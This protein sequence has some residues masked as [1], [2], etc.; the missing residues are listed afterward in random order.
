MAE[1]N[2]YIKDKI[3]SISI[4]LF[5]LILIVNG[6]IKLIFE[7]SDR[8]SSLISFFF[9]AI[10]FLHFIIKVLPIIYKRSI[11]VLL[12]SYIL[13]IILYSLSILSISSR[14]ENITYLFSIYIF[15]SFVFWIPVGVTAYSIFN[16]KILYDLLIKYSFVFTAV[17]LIVFFKSFIYMSEE[18]AMYYSMSFSYYTLFPAILHMSYYLKY[19]SKAFLFVSIT[20]VLMILLIGSRGALL[21]ILVYI[22]IKFLISN[23]S[24]FFKASR[25][26]LIVSLLLIFYLKL[27]DI[28]NIFI[29]KFNF[30]SRTLSN[31]SNKESDKFGTRTYVWNIGLKL[32]E[33]KPIF[34]YGIGGDHYPMIRNSR[35]IDSSRVAQSPHNGFIQLML[36]FG[37][38]IGLF[39]GLWIVLSLLKIRNDYS[40]FHRELIIIAFCVYVLSSITVG[41]MLLIK[42]GIAMYI[43]MIIKYKS[44]NRI[45]N[46]SN[47][48]V[49]INN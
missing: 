20:E 14:G 21:G 2:I 29:E 12:L 19:K 18:Q 39:I 25:L 1:K 10:Y 40:F 30:H 8:Q 17:L 46:F 6:S 7:L 43:Y 15:W 31:F 33:E 37:I 35:M 36:H 47:S 48:R 34:G 49:Y 5:F 9:G 16:Y 42:P 32:I 38:P 44:K 11:R 4:Y 13:F 27:D 24:F 41:D 22:I 23:K 3:L 26:I 45:Y 28:N